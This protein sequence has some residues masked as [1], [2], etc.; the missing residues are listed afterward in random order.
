M[1]T[2]QNLGNKIIKTCQGT[3]L[4]TIQNLSFKNEER[5]HKLI[6]FN[7]YILTEMIK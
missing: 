6:N 1:A 7:Y 4:N 5:T 2:S 3:T